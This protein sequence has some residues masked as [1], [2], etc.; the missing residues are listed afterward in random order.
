MDESG[1]DSHFWRSRRIWSPVRAI[2]SLQEES[3]DSKS[4][5]DLTAH[6]G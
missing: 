4:R 2:E 5:T 6:E 3:V 1:G